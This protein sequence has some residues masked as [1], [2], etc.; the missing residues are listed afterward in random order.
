MTPTTKRRFL[1][2][3]AVAG[4]LSFSQAATARELTVALFAPNAG[5]ANG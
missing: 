4:V 1:A 2:L 5:F 3:S